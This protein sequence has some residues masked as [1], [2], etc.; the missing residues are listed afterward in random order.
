MVITTAL[1]PGRSAPVLIFEDMVKGMKH[2]SVIMDL[3][4]ENGGNCELTKPGEVSISHGVIIDGTLN[5]PATM[6]KH[7]S[8]LYAKNIITFLKHLCPEGE[9]NLDLD[10]EIISGALFTHNGEITHEPTKEIL[11]NS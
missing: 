4:A 11:N 9:I 7:A 6:P 5:L 3:A 10:D 2:G 1:I 8:Q